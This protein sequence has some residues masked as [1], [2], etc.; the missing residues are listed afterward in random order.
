MPRTS[1]RKN[2]H[3]GRHENGLVGPGKR[4]SKQKSNGHINGSARGAASEDTAQPIPSSSAPLNGHLANESSASAAADAKKDT[5]LDPRSNLKHQDSETSIDGQDSS[6]NFTMAQNGSID[7][8]HRRSDVPPSKATSAYDINPVHLA[9]TILRSCPG[10]DTVALLIFLLALPSMML[11][12]VQAFFASLTFMPPTGFTP[13]TLWSFLDLFQSPVGAPSLITMTLVDLICCLLWFGLWTW[14]RRFA[15]DLAQVQIAMTLGGGNSGKGGGVNGVC[16]ALVLLVHLVR[17]RGVRDFFFGNILYAKLS[18][19]PTVAI[20]LQYL[21]SQAD[22]G[23]SMETTSTI[24]S[25]IAIHIIAQALMASIRRWLSNTPGTAT[26]KSSKR[27]DPEALAGTQNTQELQIMDS[28]VSVASSSGVDYQPPPTPGL[29]DGKDK[30]VSAKKRRRQAN[31]IRS[32]QPFWAALASTKV[33]VM[34][35]YEHTRGS[36]K[37]SGIQDSTTQEVAPG[38]EIVWI[39]GVDSSTIQF[40][41]SNLGV[42]WKEQDAAESSR[43]SKPIE[44]RINGAEWV[45]CLEEIPASDDSSST[46][47]KGEI[48]G[49]APNCTYECSFSRTGDRTDFACVSIKTPAISDKDIPKALAPPAT[50]HSGPPSSG[51][52]TIKRSIE[53]SEARLADA[54]KRLAKARKAHKTTL[55][56]VE[57]DVE[58]LNSRLGSGGDDQKQ[59]Q[60]LL[61]A[62]R[63]IKQTEEAI[64]G[65]VS[66]LED[67]EAIPE[68][69]SEEYSIKKKDFQERNTS[70]AAANQTLQAAKASASTEIAHVNTELQSVVERKKRLVAR[71]ARLTEQYDR[72]TEANAQGLNEKE[73][74]AAESAARAFEEQRAEHD[75]QEKFIFLQTDLDRYREHTSAA[76]QEITAYEAQMRAQQDAMFRNGGALTPEG[77]LPGTNPFSSNR[78]IGYG[79]SIPTSSIHAATTMPPLSEQQHSPFLAY[80]NTLPDGGA[81]RA[82]SST[83]RSTGAGS[84]FSADFDDADPIPPMPTTYEFDFKGLNGRKGSGSG[85]SREK[86]SGSPGIIGTGLGSPIKGRNSPGQPKSIW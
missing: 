16:V 64:A 28:I 6:T 22:F 21:P 80:A 69:D 42:G 58:G 78:S 71:Q 1:G 12:I 51:T 19:Y 44:V 73:R 5:L 24:R 52:T 30:A 26:V 77:N 85:S 81:R 11:T 46:H 3:N 40:E 70:L 75:F 32:R 63:S 43:C 31:Q 8:K 13:G 82:R 18:S 66:Q 50:R 34:R 37:T 74:K 10:T 59:R 86:N 62:E 7:G 55:A 45:F 35:E 9:S 47:W 83:N 27:I 39:T 72:I 68:E 67:L 41:A 15:L 20:V 4:I 53:S 57:K 49:L 48:Q 29:K 2:Q 54:Q 56:K 60:K 36:Y 84:N 23:D 17:S 79:F 65:I 38:D 14:A 33:H 61:Q 76:W 25:L